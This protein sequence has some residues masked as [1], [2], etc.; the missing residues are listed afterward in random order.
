ML[1][2]GFPIAKIKDM[3]GVSRQTIYRIKQELEH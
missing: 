1:L 3:T 2:S